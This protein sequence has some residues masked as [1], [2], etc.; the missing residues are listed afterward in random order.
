M[1]FFIRNLGKNVMA[2]CALSLDLNRLSDATSL[3][4]KLAQQKGATDAAVSASISRGLGVDVRLGEVETVSHYLD[5]E[6]SIVV[7]QDKRKAA[8]STTDLSPE[9]ISEAVDKALS[10]AK[11]TEEDLYTALAQ[12]EEL[13][14]TWPQ[15]DLY[16][17]WDVSVEKAT[18]LAQEL[19]ALAL[20]EDSKINNS[21]GANVTASES[22]FWYAASNGFSAGDL[23]SRHSLSVSVVAEENGLMQRDSDYTVARS[24]TDFEDSAL[25]AKR[26]ARG[27]VERLGARKLPTGKYP[28]L[29]RSDIATGFIGSLLS[30]ISGGNLYRKQSFL[31]DHLGKQLFPDFMQII[32]DP[33]IPRGLASTPYD[34][35]GVSVHQRKLI[36]EGVL[37]G[38]LLGTY[39]ARRLGMKST[40][41][42]GGAHNI[43]VKNTGESLEQ[44]LKKMGTGLFITELFGQGVNLMTGDYSRGGF[45]FWV[46]GGKIQYPVEEITIAGALPQMFSSIQGIGT[47]TEK[48]SKIQV[49]SIL[50][51]EMMVA[52]E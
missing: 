9:A 43:L 23:S 12:P 11:F 26:A 49:G 13:A 2:K 51:G 19:E 22:A 17:P 28:I 14:K 5:H 24:P 31:V 33:F 10:I 21:E 18:E 30:G 35:E 8:V 52:G 36:D 15:L 44:L 47:D 42:A 27:A 32:E 1:P 7:F 16:F 39:T 41:N 4:L 20:D 48:R 34:A 40:G 50:L 3:A 38:Y 25:I 45:G 6:F 46:E 37:Q 29:F